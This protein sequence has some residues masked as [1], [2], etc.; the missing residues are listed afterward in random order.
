MSPLV[1]S[2]HFASFLPS[3]FFPRSP[4]SSPVHL[5]LFPITY[6]HLTCPVHC[7]L[8]CAP[9][10]CPLS[11]P[12][13]DSSPFAPLPQSL[14]QSYFSLLSHFPISP[15]QSLRDQNAKN[16]P[17]KLHLP[18]NRAYH[19][20]AIPFSR[21]LPVRNWE[22]KQDSFFDPIKGIWRWEVRGRGLV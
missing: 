20:Q 5:S 18:N 11:P 4:V 14:G 1:A 6:A 21:W 9:L 12:S 7:L 10:I 15:P 13:S 17:V 19:G 22:P 2:I 8:S 16:Q 3:L